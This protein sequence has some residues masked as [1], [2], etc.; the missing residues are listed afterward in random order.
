MTNTVDLSQPP[1]NHRFKFEL[2]RE[3]TAA[4]RQLRLFKDFALFLLAL[5]FVGLIA[6][7]CVTT[8][9]SVT[10]SADEKKWAMSIL[11]AATGAVI[12]YLVRK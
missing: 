5:G 7:I 4:E 6:W 2:E 3:E 9:T 1:A 8:L 11:S 12:G 10:T